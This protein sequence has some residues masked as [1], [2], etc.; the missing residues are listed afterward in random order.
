MEAEMEFKD[1]PE[2]IEILPPLARDDYSR[3]KES[4]KKKGIQE[5]IKVLKDG[6]IV[7]GAHRKKIAKELKL[8]EIPFEEIEDISKDKALELGL[9]LNIARRHLSR[10]QKIEISKELLH[11]G[12]TQEQTGKLI[13]LDQSTI[14][15]M[16]KGSIMKKHI[17]SIP[18]QRYK[19]SDEDEGEIVKRAKIGEETH[20]QIAS[21]YGISR[22][23]VSQIIRKVKAREKELEPVGETGE[24]K[25]KFYKALIIDPPW[26]VK[27]IERDERPDQG[28]I[29]DYPVMSIEQ[30]KELPILKWAN[31]NGCHVYL[32]TTHKFLPIAFEVFEK[33]EVNYECLLTWVKNVGFTPFSWM[34]STEHSLFGR[35]GNLPLLKKGERLD[36]KAKVR[37]HSRKPDEFYDKIK[38]VSPEPR[39][40]LFSREKRSG[41]DQYGDEI[42]KF[43]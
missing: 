3:L 33:W 43:V 28:K 17:T 1:F 40:D 9:E 38:I 19:I 21:D 16:P 42:N 23:R 31:P 13:G 32:W 35:I 26:P 20:K 39:L 37:E 14:S 2:L 8:K 7:D 10:E 12:F 5:K 24:P 18:D 34:Y 4:I 25:E 29:L 15:K 27:K 41:F 22:R 6:T 30:I 36:F 11:R